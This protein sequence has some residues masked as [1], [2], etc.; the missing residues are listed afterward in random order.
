MIVLRYRT[1]SVSVKMLGEE[2]RVFGA[3]VVLS[4]QPPKANLGTGG[5]KINSRFLTVS[6]T[7]RSVATC[8]AIKL[9][10]VYTTLPSMHHP[11]PPPPHFLD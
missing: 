9:S 5:M 2:L 6:S 7:G 11:L 3:C 10:G 8:S 4:Q 1:C